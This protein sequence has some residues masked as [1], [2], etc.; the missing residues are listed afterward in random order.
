MVNMHWL[1]VIIG[2]NDGYKMYKDNGSEYVYHSSYPYIGSYTNS[3]YNP[4]FVPSN[5]NFVITGTNN[6]AVW[7]FKLYV[8]DSATDTWTGKATVQPSGSPTTDYQRGQ[9]GKGFTYD[10]SYFF[11]S[12]NGA[13]TQGEVWSVDWNANT[14]TYK[15]WHTEE[16]SSRSWCR[17]GNITR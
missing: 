6:S 13:T 4:A 12:S 8:Y 5:N 11:Q 1:Q 7:L 9:F 14:M 2:G 16:G 17:W 15:V 3:G 10:G